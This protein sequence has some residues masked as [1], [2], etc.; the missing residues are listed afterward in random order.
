M[1]KF[2][3]KCGKPLDECTCG[4]NQT[5]EF[6]N[7]SRG[8]FAQMKNRMGIGEVE[9]NGVPPYERGMKIIPE[10]VKASE[11]EIPVKQ[12]TVA[13]LRTRFLGIP[14]AK[15]E[16]RV[17]VT[18]KRI[19][20]RALGRSLMGHLT[21]QQEFAIDDVAGMEVRK[22]FTA[23]I[24]DFLFA[25]ILI[26]FGCSIGM[27]IVDNIETVFIKLI[28]ALLF[29]VAGMIPFFIMKKRWWQKLICTSFSLGGLIGGS[30]AE[31][32]NIDDTLIYIAALPILVAFII[33]IVNMF[34]FIIKPNL[35]MVVKTKSFTDAVDI[36]RMKNGIF[37]RIMGGQMQEHTGYTEVIPI[38]NSEEAI[39]ELGAVITDIQ[40]FGDFGIEKWQEPR[41]KT[42]G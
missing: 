16:G 4:R 18:N 26:T 32:G 9:T 27:G 42:N 24:W 10:C 29:G 38:E 11:G 37:A 30:M 23:S 40:K 2:C 36:Q 17:E 7:Q 22:E 20:F 33:V 35:V 34:L 14:I 21:L 31:I 25:I 12:Y 39:R 19:I 28:L 15:A 3:T 8:A 1:A 6:L 5:T 41:F 13:K